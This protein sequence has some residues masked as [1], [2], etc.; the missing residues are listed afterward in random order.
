MTVGKNRLEREWVLLSVINPSRTMNLP[1]LEETLCL[2]AINKE[3]SLDFHTGRNW[4]HICVWCHL[5]RQEC[6]PWIRESQEDKVH[7]QGLG[8]CA[9]LLM[10]RISF[11]FGP[12]IR[13]TDH[14]TRIIV[15]VTMRHLT[16]RN[17]EAAH[18]VSGFRSNQS[19][20][21]NRVEISACFVPSCVPVRQMILTHNRWS[22]NIYQVNDYLQ[23]QIGSDSTLFTLRDELFLGVCNH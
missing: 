23:E 14:P 4:L 18:P 10:W 11:P 15:T 19:R 2:T 6:H 7:R 16:Q 9:P 12:A 8:L 22:I 21:M 13:D 3:G 17:K 5:A 20:E 1:R